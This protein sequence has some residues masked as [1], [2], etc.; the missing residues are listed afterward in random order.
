[1]MTHPLIVLGTDTDA[2]KTTFSLLWLAAFSNQYEYWKPLET[3][4]SDSDTI[5]RL[6][7][8]AIVHA[9]TM[10]FPEAVAPALAAR[11]NGQTIPPAATLAAAQPAVTVSSRTLLIETFGSPL[12]PLNAS[13]LQVTLIRQLSGRCVLV[14]ASAIGAVGRLLQAVVSLESFGIRPV[15]IVLMGKSDSYAESEITRH[16][17]MIPVFSLQPPPTWDREALTQSAQAQRQKLEQI[18]TIVATPTPSRTATPHWLTTD[19]QLIWHPYSSLQPATAPLPVVGAEAEFLELSD[20]RRIV[21]AVSSW[22]TILH[23]HRH[24]P[25]MQ[26]LAKAVQRID[27]VLFAGVTHPDAV[28]FAERILRTCPWTGGRV[29]FSDN[30]STAIEVALKMAYQFWC[31]HGEPQ[32]KL[33]I[34]FDHAYHGDTFGAMSIGRDRLFFGHF[35]P[36]LFD[37]IQLPL[38]PDQLDDFLAQRG[39]EVA[40]V[41]VE[42]LIQGAGG[43]RMHSPQTLRNLYA[44]AKR[45]GI[46]FIADEVMTGNRTGKRWAFQHAGIAPDLIATAKTLAGGILPLAVTLAAPGIVAAF[47]TPERARSFFHGHS[48]TAHPLACA[49]AAANEALIAEPGVL[50]RATEIGVFLRTALDDLTDHPRVRE[51]RSLGSIVAVAGNADG[52]YLASEAERWKAVALAQG[53]FLRPLGNVLYALPPLGITEASLAQISTA[54]RAAFDS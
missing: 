27:H 20:G 15:A 6:V 26:E 8:E 38:D 44:A 13:E 1:M 33:F 2:G 21:D 51:I 53:V 18:Q 42:P 19:A 54:I 46:L 47:D 12:S 7:P 49:L 29:F 4:V 22:W 17:P 11:H 9:P 10:H 45:H 32:R 5:H 25:L 52:G 37:A 14:G 36:L 43:M 40:G 34:G 16:Q 31:H 3:G 41:I 48:F 50:E 28:Q 39:Q 23:G 30:G 35:E 24:P